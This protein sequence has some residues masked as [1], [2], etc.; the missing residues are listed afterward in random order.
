MKKDDNKSADNKSAEDG[1]VRPVIK[2][3]LRVPKIVEDNESQQN[4]SVADPQ[5]LSLTDTNPKNNSTDSQSSS[6]THKFYGT[7]KYRPFKL[8][9]LLPPGSRYRVL[10]PAKYT[11]NLARQPAVRRNYF[12]G[13]SGGRFTDD[14]DL[15]CVVV[16]EGLW[17]TEQ[18]LEGVS[19]LVE[20]EVL[21]DHIS[22]TVSEKD[23]DPLKSLK[24]SEPPTSLKDSEPPT[25]LSLNPRKYSN[26]D[27]HHIKVTNCILNPGT[28]H[29]KR[30]R[31]H[32]K[33]QD[34]INKITT[35]N[36]K[37]ESGFV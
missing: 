32:Q 12:W 9:P 3:K 19:W 20:V 28:V 7:F 30:W 25:S 15:V 17:G 8:F 18:Q 5:T 11:R 14:S 10:I 21:D 26:H 29:L 24:D 34:Q 31:K 6:S 36:F 16:W 2:L 35:P 1:V 33:H 37:T 22:T 4:L 23:S 27:G 13:G